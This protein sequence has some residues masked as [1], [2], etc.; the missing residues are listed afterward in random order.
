MRHAF[1]GCKSTRGRS[2]NV[3]HFPLGM[4]VN[5]LQ[6]AL[7]NSCIS[8]QIIGLGKSYNLLPGKKCRPLRVIWVD[9]GKNLEELF[10]TLG[11]HKLGFII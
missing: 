8:F 5:K 7:E 11:T 4:D 10:P 1:S 6:Q 2:L 9:M 3:L